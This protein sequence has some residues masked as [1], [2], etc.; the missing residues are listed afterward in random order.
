[1]HYFVPRRCAVTHKIMYHNRTIAQEAAY[2][3]YLE[4]GTQLWVYQCAD[5]DTW[6]LTSQEPTQQQRQHMNTNRYKQR[7]RKHAYKPKRR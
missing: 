2:K 4:R 5:C 3:S 7:S 6:H 1:M